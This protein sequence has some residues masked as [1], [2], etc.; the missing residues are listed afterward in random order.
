MESP[1][2][3]D[4]LRARLA[5][6]DEL[7]D[8]ILRQLLIVLHERG[9]I[10][11]DELRRRPRRRSDAGDRRGNR[12]SAERWDRRVREWLD[13]RVFEEAARG[14]SS[15]EIDE[16]LNLVLRR[17]R[18][19]DL[20]DLASREKAPVGLVRRAV[21]EFRRLAHGGPPLKP[22]EILGTRVALI[23]RFLTDQLSLIHVARE[24]VR[25]RDLVPV[26]ERMITAEPEGGRVGGKGAGLLLSWSIVRKALADQPQRLA[27]VVLPET[28]YLTSDVHEAFIDHNRLQEYRNHKYRPIGDLR[29]E[30][31]LIT[32]IFCNCRLP[33]AV[34]RRLA[35]M[36]EEI[37]PEPIIVRSS[38]LLE[39]S[40]G[41]AFSGMYKSIFLGN[42]GSLEQRLEALGD[43]IAEIYAGVCAPDPVSYRV[44]HRLQ[45]V[46]ECMGLLV[47]K[48]VGRR[49]GRWFFPLVAGVA[50][51]VND[52]LWD[53]RLRREDGMARL[54]L[55]LGTRAVDRMADDWPRLVA[56]GEPTLRPESDAAQIARGS[57]R[58]VDA[59]DLEADAFVSLP[60]DELLQAGWVPGL[61]GLVVRLRE[62]WLEEAKTEPADRGGPWLATLDG[63]LAD[64]VFA[65]LLRD[66][67]QAVQRAYGRPVELEFAWDGEHLVLLQGRVLARWPEVA[68]RWPDPEPERILFRGRGRVPDGEVRGVDWLGWLDPRAWAKAD[69]GLRERLT[70]AVGRLDDKLAGSRVIWLGPGR[71]GS[72]NPEL[73]V[74]VHFSDIA[75]ASALVEVARDQGGQR[76]EVS[77]GTHFLQD[78]IE[79]GIY[80][81]PL[82]PDDEEAHFD[83]LRLLRAPNHLCAWLPDAGDLELFL[84]LVRPD[85]IRPGR[86]DLVLDGEGG[87]LI[88]C[89]DR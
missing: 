29:R 3:E 54:V 10:G 80:C 40:F 35:E 28:W 70:A 13:R 7:K 69:E 75:H 27:R 64:G 1:I 6:Y 73:G 51:S 56:L 88:G 21:K 18:S 89:W 31:E 84:R 79:A 45:D 52:Y 66:V 22:S 59:I 19:A 43:A 87:R 34:E 39:D 81:L 42:Q 53:A 50:H 25:L 23:R 15:R 74:P 55:G 57:Q 12:P 85:Q 17:E 33:P 14:L 83:E 8:R 65:E 38:S 60:L 4:A 24:A 68:A 62:G 16:L 61:E 77:Y 20:E 46:N 47:Q 36:L 26:L 32:E 41:L 76:P 86:F 2:G 37:G 72:S 71:W 11:V 67:L 30:H 58:M 44:R 78:L 9:R 48:V 63:L 49:H 5:P 82:F